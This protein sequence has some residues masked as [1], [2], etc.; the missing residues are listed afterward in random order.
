[1]VLLMMY[2][3]GIVDDIVMVLL[4]GEFEKQIIDIIL[5]TG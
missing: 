2:Y 3:H 4:T 1:M 5:N